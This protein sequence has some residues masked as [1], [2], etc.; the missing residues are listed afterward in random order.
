M[1]FS[2]QNLAGLFLF[3]CGCLFL[4]LAVREESIPPAQPEP[5]D[6]EPFRC[7]ICGYFYPARKG[8]ELSSCPRCGTIN[9][10]ED[11]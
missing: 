9:R 7:P 8:E 4:Y 1:I 2:P 5:D 6:T 10:K 3:I 11:A